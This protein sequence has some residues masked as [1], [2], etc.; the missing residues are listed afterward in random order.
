MEYG[1]ETNI[2]PR[3]V[4]LKRS[5]SLWA[6][7]AGFALISLLGWMR[8][9][10]SIQ[11]WYW[12]NVAGVDPGP[13]YLAV[14]GGLWGLVGLLALIWMLLDRPWSRLVGLAAALLFALTYW[15]DQLFIANRDSAGANLPFAALF[16]LLCLLYAVLTLRP[17]PE[18]RAIMR[19]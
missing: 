15:I 12:L 7:W 6:L 2:S 13:L 3:P 17:L 10:D 11:D 9:V 8:M 14:T 4:R 16:T 18:V 19:R 5:I 1:L